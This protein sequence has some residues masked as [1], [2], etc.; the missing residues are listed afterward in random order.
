MLISSK[1]ISACF[2]VCK[3]NTNKTIIKENYINVLTEQNVFISQNSNGAYC[4]K[5][6]WQKEEEIIFLQ[7]CLNIA[8]ICKAISPCM[9]IKA[10]QITK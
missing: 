10:L 2:E 3:A 6:S 8:I 9:H 1:N 5:S 4:I 7:T